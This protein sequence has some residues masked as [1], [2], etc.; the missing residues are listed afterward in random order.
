[1]SYSIDAIPYKNKFNLIHME[2]SSV[3]SM[4]DGETCDRKT[5]AFNIFRIWNNSIVAHNFEFHRLHFIH[6]ECY[7]HQLIGICVNIQVWLFSNASWLCPNGSQI[8]N[9]IHICDRLYLKYVLNFSNFSSFFFSSFFSVFIHRFA[10]IA[11]NLPRITARQR[12]ISG[13]NG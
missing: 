5:M 4:M 2:L 12:N 1:M 8:Y 13:G 6:C 9:A 3:R 11:T 10:A 7:H